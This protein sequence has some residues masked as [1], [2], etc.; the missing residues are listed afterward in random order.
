MDIFSGMTGLEFIYTPTARGLTVE[1]QS[2][3]IEFVDGRGMFSSS[4]KMNVKWRDMRALISD[5][6]SN[7]NTKALI[8]PQLTMLLNQL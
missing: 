2:R 3:L 7:P 5:S 8:G 6:K 4:Q 1:Q